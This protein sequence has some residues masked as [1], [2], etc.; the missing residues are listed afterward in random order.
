MK[1]LQWFCVALYNDTVLTGAQAG[2]TQTFTSIVNQHTALK[3][4]RLD[5]QRSCYKAN[6][7]WVTMAVYTIVDNP[8]ISFQHLDHGTVL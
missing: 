7:V 1:Q 8:L 3:Q 6:K 4:E 2:G 5:S